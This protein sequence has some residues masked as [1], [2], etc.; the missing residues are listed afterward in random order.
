M[1]H[2]PTAGDIDRYQNAGL[3]LIFNLGN[4]QVATAWHDLCVAIEPPAAELRFQKLIDRVESHPPGRPPVRTRSCPMVSMIHCSRSN[5]DESITMLFRKLGPA[6]I[7][8]P[9]PGSQLGLLDHWHTAHR[10]P[11]P[12]NLAVR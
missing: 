4:G 5:L 6:D 8:R 1:D 7:N 11:S 2:S 12:D 3:L 10:S 9:C